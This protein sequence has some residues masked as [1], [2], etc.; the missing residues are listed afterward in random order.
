M[1]PPL[2]LVVVLTLLMASGAA[3]HSWYDLICC[4]T[5]DCAPVKAHVIRATADGWLVEVRPGEHLYATRP[6]Q[7]LIPYDSTKV[8]PSQDSDFHLCLGKSGAIYCIYV[9]VFGS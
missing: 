8:R 2:H 1:V 4:N 6:I 7:K 9:P 3:A 5:D